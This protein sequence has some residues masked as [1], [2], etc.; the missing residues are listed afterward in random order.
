VALA[1]LDSRIGGGWVRR[2][3]RAITAS[4]HPPEKSAPGFMVQAYISY[5]LQQT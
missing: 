2:I 4:A 1:V 5:V 3:V